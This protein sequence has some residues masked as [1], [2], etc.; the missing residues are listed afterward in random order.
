MKIAARFPIKTAP[1]FHFTWLALYAAMA[2]LGCFFLDFSWILFL[3]LLVL[4]AAS[5]FSERHYRQL[6]Q[7][8]D[9]LCWNGSDWLTF[10]NDTLRSVIYLRL[11][12]CSW[13]SSFACLLHFSSEQGEY[14]WLFTRAGLGERAYRELC[15]LA[16]QSL[17]AQLK[18]K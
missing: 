1:L 12:P 7:A 18:E 14:V 2:A 3:F 5:Y 17:R 11:K 10:S 16:Q 15:Y 8:T 4:I 9:D 6:T 13:R